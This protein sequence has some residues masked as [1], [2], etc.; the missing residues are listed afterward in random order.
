MAPVT[1]SSTPGILVTAPRSLAGPP[2]P[3]SSAAGVNPQSSMSMTASVERLAAALA[4]RYVLQHE[5][6]AGGTATVYPAEDGVYRLA[7]AVDRDVPW[8]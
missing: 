4:E 8:T 1:T 7:A 2:R 3:V 5:L 6:G